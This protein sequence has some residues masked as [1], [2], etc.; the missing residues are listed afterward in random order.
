MS[1]VLNI[2]ALMVIIMTKHLFN[3][4][5]NNSIR[6][7]RNSIKEAF[8][9]LPSGVCYFNH[10]GRLI[11]CNKQMFKLCFYLTLRELQIVTDLENALKCLPTNSNVVKE[12]DYYI[13]PDGTI[14][15]FFHAF[16]GKEE[17]YQEYIASNVTTLYE[18][19]KALKTSTI[20]REIMGDKMRQI[21]NNIVAITREEE[22]ISMKM[23]VHNKVGEALQRL[24]HF[25]VS[26]MPQE[27]KEE[28]VNTYNDLI[29]VLMGE[30]GNND[31]EDDLGEL[32]RIASTLEINI[33]N[34]GMIPLEKIS[35]DIIIMSLRESITNTIRHAKGNHIILDIDDK[36][37]NISFTITN[38]GNLPTSSIVEGGGLTSLRKRIE[39]AQGVMKIEYIN[40]FK[41]IVSI[42]KNRK[43]LL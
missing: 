24:R 12:G 16:V 38:N 13:F 30:V 31:E 27:E 8:D 22:I 35:R 5:K 43:E 18:K 41:L 2:N 15:R 33:D 28:L 42:P 21:S 4:K 26:G 14:W 37:S 7:P 32:L 11:L 23:L 9:N 1:G 25:K 29:N 3:K 34:N 17:V 40:K 20:E 39:M 6:V 19:Q 10:N 36:E